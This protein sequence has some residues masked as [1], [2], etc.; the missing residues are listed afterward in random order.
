M[1]SPLAKTY[2]LLLLP[3][4][5]LFSCGPSDKEVFMEDF[6]VMMA[7]VKHQRVTYTVNDWEE[8]DEKLNEL[9]DEHYQDFEDELTEEEKR[10]IWGEVFSY[11]VYQHGDDVIDHIERNEE[12]YMRML[13]RNLDLVEAMGDEFFHHILPELKEMGPEI[14]A[15]TEKLVRRLEKRG[16]L[17][18]LENILEDFGKDMEEL[19][20]DL[21]KNE[22]YERQSRRDEE[23]QDQLF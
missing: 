4:L 20:K 19:S 23:S 3:A 5:W 21:E 22:R 16:T 7:E 12:V 14:Q 1:K 15:L 18:R 6:D 10:H 9:L 17:D 2:L 8:Q 13:E 11:G